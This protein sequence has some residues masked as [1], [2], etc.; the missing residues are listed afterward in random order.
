MANDHP[1]SLRLGFGYHQAR[2]SG[3]G[4]IRPDRSPNQVNRYVSGSKAAREIT[5]EIEN[6]PEMGEFVVHWIQNGISAEE[7]LEDMSRLRQFMRMKK[8]GYSLP[9]RIKYCWRYVK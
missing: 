6:D 5:R 1:T 2:K 9:Y 4:G 3:L 8:T 7:T